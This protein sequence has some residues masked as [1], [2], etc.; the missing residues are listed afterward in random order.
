MR[1]VFKKGSDY[2]LSVFLDLLNLKI[3]FK[4]LVNVNKENI[5]KLLIL[6][7][8]Y[9]LIKLIFVDWK[10][11]NI[12]YCIYIKYFWLYEIY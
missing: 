6:K 3:L 11:F 2:L 1:I 10:I 4:N 9:L 8:E 5:W 7:F 12:E